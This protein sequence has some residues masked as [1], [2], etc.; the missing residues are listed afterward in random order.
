[1]DHYSHQRVFRSCSSADPG[2]LVAWEA[3][4]RGWW[5]LNT[6]TEEGFQS[7]D[8][9]LDTANELDPNWSWP[10]ADKIACFV[11][12]VITSAAGHHNAGNRKR[13]LGHGKFALNND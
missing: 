11:I 13:T 4:H 6:E 7:A 9:W 2:K 8:E 12:S 5:Y 1:V 10:Y 3:A